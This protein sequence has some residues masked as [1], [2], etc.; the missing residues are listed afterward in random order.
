MNEFLADGVPT[1]LN[2]DQITTVQLGGAT[3]CFVP[4]D[5]QTEA[6]EGPFDVLLHLILREEVD[7]YEISVVRIV[8][9][10]LAHVATLDH[11]DLELTTEF[12]L[13]AATLVQL[14]TRRLLPDEDPL[15]LDEELAIW[16]ERD[17]LL[18]RLLECKT[19]KD[20][21]SALARLSE[22]A[23]HSV[24]R[25]A[26]LEDR[27]ADLAPDPMIGVT[28]ERIREAFRRAV[29]PRI[30]PT[31]QLDHIAPIRASVA[32]AVVE[33]ADELRRAG[34]ISFRRLTASLGTRLEV[35]VR[36]LAVLELFKQDRVDLDQT[37]TFGDIRVTWR[38][39]VQATSPL[40]PSWPGT[41][42][43]V[44]AYDG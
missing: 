16:S 19:F 37:E 17:L 41:A 20:A 25:T 1:S 14:K 42:A 15:T 9:A 13:I 8:D 21:A 38:D 10:F 29:T 33:I 31:I 18:A 5:V 6:F 34:T 28:P 22:V 4:Y 44:D 23:A 36:F 35:V 27:F 30:Q 40:D 39:D 3:I 24:P 2:R 43:L 26:G 12:L 7:L 32:D 11:P